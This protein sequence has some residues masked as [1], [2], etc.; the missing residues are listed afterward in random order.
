M[1]FPTGSNPDLQLALRMNCRVSDAAAF[2]GHS[3]L[4]QAAEIIILLTSDLQKSAMVCLGAENSDNKI[5]LVDM[6]KI[7][8]TN[9]IHDLCILSC[10][11][12]HPY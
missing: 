12:L 7:R 8:V 10:D 5:I 6:I 11:I 4:A 2:L 9:I 3:R 1:C